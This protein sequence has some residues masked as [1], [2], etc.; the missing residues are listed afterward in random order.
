MI[1]EEVFE[2]QG[3]EKRWNREW[4]LEAKRRIEEGKVTI[5]VS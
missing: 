5:E 3:G 2:G 1:R 4:K